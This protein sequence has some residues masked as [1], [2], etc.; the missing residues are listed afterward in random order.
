VLAIPG[1]PAVA[2]SAAAPVS[3]SQLRTVRFGSTQ[4]ASDA[5]VFIGRERGYFREQGIEVDYVPFQSGPD[6]M[7]PMAS[8]DLEVGSGNFGIVWLNAVERGVG[9]KGVA[10]KGSARPGFEFVQVPLRRDLVES[11]QV[12]TPADLRGRR[13]G[14]SVLRSGGEALVADMLARGGLTPDDVDLVALGY[15]EMLAGLANRAL[16]AAVLIEP[17]L[18]AAVARGLVATWEPGY[19]STAFGGAYQASLVFYSGQFAAQTDLARR[20]MVA[21]LKGVRAYNDAFLRGEGRADAV[22]ILT[23]TTA[24]KDPAVYDLMQMAGLDP[25]GRINQQSLE[26]ELSYYRARGYYTGPVTPDQVIDS[27]FAEYA[28]QQL[29]PYR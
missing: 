8:G 11:G 2:S 7:V 1:Q 5:G 10:D 29:G 9:I 4:S 26:R 15:P 22:R 18:S 19:G 23:E 24:I 27:S 20:F 16:D 3:A 14:M 25:D 13:I 17:S 28:A 12:R 21:Y 6:T